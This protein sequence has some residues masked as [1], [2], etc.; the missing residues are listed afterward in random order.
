MRNSIGDRGE[1][2]FEVLITKYISG[3]GRLFTPTF[4]GDKHPLIDFHIDLLGHPYPAFFHASIKTTRQGY[5]IKKDRLKVTIPKSDKAALAKCIV[6]VF[7]FGI[8]E[9]LEKGYLACAHHIHNQ[10]ITGN[11]ST[12]FPM[13]EVN[14]LKLHKEVS[15]YWENNR[16]KTKFV[17]LFK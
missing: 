14:L 16:E 5:T 6:P 12:S 11:I 17:S 7:I 3:M 9:E 10:L 15:A 8:D 4:L 13:A 1:S 2:I